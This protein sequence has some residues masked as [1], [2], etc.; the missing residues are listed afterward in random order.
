MFKGL[1]SGI[2][3]DVKGRAS[4]EL[5]MGDE[6]SA[7]GRLVQRQALA[8]NPRFNM[9]ILDIPCQPRPGP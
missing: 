7:K 5:K 4:V 2:E 1:G 8:R 9:G 6:G 3:V